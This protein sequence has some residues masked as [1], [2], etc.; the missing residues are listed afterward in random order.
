MHFTVV[1]PVK[2]CVRRTYFPFDFPAF[3]RYVTG[4]GRPDLFAR[5]GTPGAVCRE[6][7]APGAPLGQSVV[8]GEPAM[9]RSGVGCSS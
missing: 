2:K 6:R 9:E 7:A 8:R 4:L 5:R 3:L 1:E